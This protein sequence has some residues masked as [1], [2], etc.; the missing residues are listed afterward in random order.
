[1]LLVWVAA[2]NR[3]PRVFANPDTFDPGR[4]STTHLALGRGIHFCLGALLARVE[5]SIVLNILR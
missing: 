3:D 5:G 4:N 2:A 1:M